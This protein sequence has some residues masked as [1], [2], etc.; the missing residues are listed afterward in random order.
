MSNDLEAEN[1][2]VFVVGRVVLRT[3]NLKTSRRRLVDYVKKLHQKACRTC[4]ARLFFLIQPI[5]SFICGVGVVVAVA[6][7]VVVS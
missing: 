1:E 4:T 2:R 7:D 6:I 5:K 3:S